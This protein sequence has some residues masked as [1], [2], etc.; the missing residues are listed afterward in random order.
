MFPESK[1]SPVRFREN[2]VGVAIASDIVAQLS[3]PPRGIC[4]WPRSMNGAT[5][6]EAA[7][8]E[9]SDPGANE[10]QIG[11]TASPGKRPINPKAKPSPVNS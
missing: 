1:H 9:Y 7:I 4:L 2:R 8:D 5:M 10:H 11:P 3:S 6:P